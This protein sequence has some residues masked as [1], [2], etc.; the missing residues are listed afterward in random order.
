MNAREMYVF[1]N[2]P[3]RIYNVS[4]ILNIVESDNWIVQPKWD[5]HRALPHC[6]ENGKVTVFSRQGTPLTLAK[7]DF[8]WLSLLPIPRPW[9]LDGELLRDGR[10]IIWD[11]AFMGISE[12]G[13]PNYVCK[14]EYGSRLSELQKIFD[15]KFTKNKFSIELIDTYPAK[16]YNRIMLKAGDKNLEGFVLKN[17]AAIDLWGISST[18][19][20]SSQLKFRFK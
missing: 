9:L 7:K 17:K 10:M 14:K 19:E 2:K 12:S 13:I 4:R 6:D 5:G 3:L 1:P 8:T 11:Y 20:V 16:V 18:R 15:Q